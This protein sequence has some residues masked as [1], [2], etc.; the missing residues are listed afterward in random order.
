MATAK[1]KLMIAQLIMIKHMPFFGHLAYYLKTVETEQLP[2]KLML[3]TEQGSVEIN[4]FAPL[5]TAAV[6]GKRLFYNPKFVDD[7]TQKA[8]IYVYCH[9][10]LHCALEH[11][12]DGRAKTRNRKKWNAAIDY[13][14]NGII[15]QQ[16]SSYVERPVHYPPLVDEKYFGWNAEKIYDD[17]PDKEYSKMD[18]HLAPGEGDGPIDETEWKIRLLEAYNFAKAQGKLPGGID[19]LLDGIRNPKISW[20]EKLRRFVDQFSREDF[21]FMRPNRRFLHQDLYLPSQKSESLGDICVFVDTSGSI[22]NQDLEQFFGEI[23]DIKS[24]FLMTLHVI[25]CDAAIQDHK[26]YDQFDPVETVHVDVHGR[27]G[28][29]FVPPFEYVQ[30]KNIQPKCAIYLTDGYGDFPQSAPEYPVLWISTTEATYPW[31]EVT[32]LDTHA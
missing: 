6:D 25:Q 20:K 12:G 4:G 9:E 32:Q 22:S 24:S 8:L 31:G 18:S 14:V 15:E 26:T 1:E 13:V 28:T 3:D 27:G 10:I 19:G 29:S 5:P 30:E 11:V 7:M 2:A 16:K 21:S 23:N 17:L